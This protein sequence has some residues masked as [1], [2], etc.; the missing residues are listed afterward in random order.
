MMG[1]SL[2]RH[3]SLNDRVVNG[4]IRFFDRYAVPVSKALDS[5][6]RPFFGQSV[7]CIARRR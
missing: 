3:K 1:Q 5:V 6:F 4:Q 7:A 2:E